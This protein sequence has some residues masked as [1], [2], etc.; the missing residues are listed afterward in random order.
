MG[1]AGAAGSRASQVEQQTLLPRGDRAGRG[2]QELRDVHP[3]GDRQCGGRD[4]QVDQA[5]AAGCCRG[6]C[7]EATEGRQK[8][9]LRTSSYW[10]NT[11]ETKKQDLQYS[12]ET[13]ICQ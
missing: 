13:G 5:W 4:E 8:Q 2:G 9:R 3:G 10:W 12:P 11:N 1:R 6:W 7:R